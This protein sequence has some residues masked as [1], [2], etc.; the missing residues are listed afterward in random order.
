ML[1]AYFNRKEYLRHRAVSLRQHSFLVCSYRLRRD[2][3]VNRYIAIKNALTARR[4]HAVSDVS[5]LVKSIGKGI[6]VKVSPILFEKVSVL[7]SAILSVQSIGIVI[8]NT[9]C[10]YR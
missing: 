1:L 10:K 5:R 4:F 6:D 3:A 9:F 2:R 8:G 7:V